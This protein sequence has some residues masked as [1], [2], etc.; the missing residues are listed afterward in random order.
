MVTSKDEGTVSDKKWREVSEKCE[1]L[2]ISMLISKIIFN[3][4]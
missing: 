1:G 4:I 3:F 2:Q